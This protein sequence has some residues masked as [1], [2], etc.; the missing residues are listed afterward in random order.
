MTSQRHENFR[1]VEC[2]SVLIPDISSK[3]QFL[4]AVN[5]HMYNV[6]EINDNNRIRPYDA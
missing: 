4:L 6:C 1:L 2:R 5:I 3:M